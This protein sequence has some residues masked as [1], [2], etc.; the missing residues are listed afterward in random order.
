VITNYPVIANTL[1][2]ASAISTRAQWHAEDG[3]IP[4]T[5]IDRI[6]KETGLGR[7]NLR[8]ALYGTEAVVDAQLANVNAAFSAIAGARTSVRKYFRDT[9]RD[10]VAPRDFCHLGIPSLEVLSALNW[11]CE[12][13]AHMAVAP[14]APLVG[15]EARKLCE[16]VSGI[17]HAHGFDYLHGV[18]VASPRAFIHVAEFT[19]DPRNEQETL[20]VEA[21]C[22]AIL[23]ATAEAGYGDY[24]AHITHMD[25]IA[26]TYDFNQ[27]ALLKL[28]QAL[29]DVLDPNGILSP[30]KQGV[31]PRSL[32]RESSSGATVGGA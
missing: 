26:R 11:R 14:V 15:R 22:R 7:W 20:R 28:Q 18:L 13:G 2:V 3:L 23:K 31:W 25:A 27:G 12:G 1:T 30:G 16:L 29:K 10:Q 8:F 5:T 9:P 24:R 6:C 21:A 32:R 19:Y 17:A 4:E